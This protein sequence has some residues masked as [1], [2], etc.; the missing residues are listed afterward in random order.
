MNVEKNKQN[1]SKQYGVKSKKIEDILDKLK[2]TIINSVGN[3]K[4]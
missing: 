3:N 2:R 4:K 1:T